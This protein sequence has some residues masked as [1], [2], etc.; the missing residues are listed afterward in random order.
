MQGDLATRVLAVAVD[1]ETRVNGVTFSGQDGTVFCS[2][3]LDYPADLVSMLESVR[4]VR[5]ITADRSCRVL[6]A[7]T[8]D[9][10]GG[11][12][13]I[14][15]TT[16]TPPVTETTLLESVTTTLP[17][18]I[19]DSELFESVLGGDPILTTMARLVRASALIS[20]LDEVPILLAPVDGAFDNFGADLLAEIESDQ[21]LI[22]EF[23]DRHVLLDPQGDRVSQEGELTRID[24]RASVI[25]KLQVGPHE[26]WLIDGVL[27]PVDDT[28][29]PPLVITFTDGV[30]EVEGTIDDASVIDAIAT[31]VEGAEVGLNLRATASSSPT[32]GM[33]ELISIVELQRLVLA[34][35]STLDA[36]VITVRDDGV[37]VVGTY[38]DEMSAESL[39]AVANAIGVRTSLAPRPPVSESEVDA[40][41]D[42]IS[43]LLAENP[44]KFVAGKSDI[45]WMTD[46]VLDEIAQILESTPGIHAIVRGHTDSDGVASS[47]LSLSAVRA[48][49][50]VDALTDRGVPSS[51]LS[52]EGVGDTEPI[53]VDGIEEKVLSRRIEIVV[54]L[55]S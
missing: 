15:S 19:A 39:A 16:T 9:G 5:R 36:A 4:G 50:V 20:R 52:S 26:I 38:I 18:A 8:V 35:L 6:K 51:M 14:A 40:I 32:I 13:D 25:E 29:L 1:A 12:T 17:L 11:T 2:E 37:D 49:A 3:P 47:N 33:P 48:K 28:V 23:V 7:P 46:A 31:T 27:V 44:V 53:L 55:A 21:A 34:V 30:V 41:N 10:S 43:E 22:V 54:E 45:V 42:A 24:G